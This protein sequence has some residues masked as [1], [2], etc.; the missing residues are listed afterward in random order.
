[1]DFA[2]DVLDGD[3]YTYLSTYL[4]DSGNLGKLKKALTDCDRTDLAVN[5]YYSPVTDAGLAGAMSAREVATTFFSK[6]VAAYSA[7]DPG[8]A[9]YYLGWSLHSVQDLWVPFHSN[10]DPV[11]GHTAYE[12]FANE[13][14]FDWGAAA[15]GIYDI[16]S[17]ASDW[18]FYAANASYSYYDGVSGVNATDAHFDLALTV[19]WP[20]AVAE[21]TGYIKFFADTIGLGVFS[22]WRE[23]AGINYVKVVWDEVTGENF[24]AY[25]V[26]FST[27]E[28]EVYDHDPTV[29]FNDRTQT[30]R[31]ITGLEIGTD[32]YV[33]IRAYC[34]GTVTQ[35]NLLKVSPQWGALFWLPIAVTG[36]IAV[37]M[38]VAMKHKKPRKVRR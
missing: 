24:T 32:Y 6:A 10:L 26:Y 22:L 21:T 7:G 35:S 17:N 13:Y 28:D 15:H 14:R 12:T 8:T 31:T 5:H 9:W 3:G 34:N 18:A 33:R 30:E 25:E 11:N 1:M 36:V 23:K 29:T 27:D 16:S 20:R 4:S 19:L 37:F 38:L 2:L